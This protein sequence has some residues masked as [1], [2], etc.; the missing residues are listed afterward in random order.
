[1]QDNIHESP[2]FAQSVQLLI[3]KKLK[4]LRPCLCCGE[5]RTRRGGRLVAHANGVRVRVTFV[6]RFCVALLSLAIAAPVVSD[7]VIG[8]QRGRVLA[9]KPRR[10]FGALVQGGAAA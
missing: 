3:A 10:Q 7:N 6:C 2:P 8:A 9:F 1:M 4:G 5:Q